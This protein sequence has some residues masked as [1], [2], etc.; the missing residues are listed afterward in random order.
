MMNNKLIAMP[1]MAVLGAVLSVLIAAPGCLG[2]HQTHNDWFVHV[3]AAGLVQGSE[4]IV[5]ATLL[6]ETTLDETTLQIPRNAR[7]DANSPVSLT[8]TRRRFSVAESLKGSASPGDAVTVA[9]SAGFTLQNRE[10]G[11]LEFWPYEVVPLQPGE[12]Y[13]LFLNRRHQNSEFPGE[14]TST[15]WEL[16]WGPDAARIDSDGRLGFFG[17]RYYQIAL[18]DMKLKPVRGSAAPF[19]LTIAGIR[20]LVASGRPLPQ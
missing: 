15:L 10:S 5:V 3:E 11:E 9:W 20:E 4:R 12:D 17:T 7:P 1:C 6:D 2:L 14:V 19:E 13:V 8:Q 16:A 18:D